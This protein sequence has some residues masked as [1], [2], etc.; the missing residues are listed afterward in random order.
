MNALRIASEIVK[1]VAATVVPWRSSLDYHDDWP[2]Y[3]NG[4]FSE[5][6]E[7]LASLGFSLTGKAV[8]E[9]GPGPSL[10]AIYL[11]RVRGA[12][13]ATAIDIRNCLVADASPI[14][15]LD[16]VHYLVPCGADSIDLP[17]ASLDLV[18]SHAVLE[19]VRAPKRV[20]AEQWRLLRPGGFVS[21]Q[22]DTRNHLDFKRPTDHRN[23]PEIVWRMM[24]WN[25]S[26]YTNR[27]TIGKWIELFSG[28]G[29]KVV[30]AHETPSL[31]R[32]EQPDGGLLLR[33]QKPTDAREA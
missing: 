3:G 13:T 27:C 11:C 33:A 20:V 5:H 32:P 28:Q 7:G 17:P 30:D 29:F 19:H 23:I 12:E 18:F 4:V 10:W 2:S 21:H 16:K 9:I 25:R 15:A 22:I 24:T 26:V 8:L 14:D 31:E 6:V 1:N